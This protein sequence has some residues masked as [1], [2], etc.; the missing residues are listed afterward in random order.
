LTLNRLLLLHIDDSLKIVQ[1]R[2]TTS[3][4]KGKLPD[5]I[6]HYWYSGT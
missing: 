5:D 4:L 3:V 2:P 6:I 1:T